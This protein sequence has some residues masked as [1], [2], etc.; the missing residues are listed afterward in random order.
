MSQHPLPT[1]FVPG[2]SKLLTHGGGR[3]GSGGR[4]RVFFFRDRTEVGG[5][6]LGLEDPMVGVTHH[7]LE[8]F[9]TNNVVEIRAPPLGSGP[10]VK[11]PLR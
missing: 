9:P 4:S 6:V 10:L 3:N 2:V 1:S 5:S 11:P 7:I 8:T